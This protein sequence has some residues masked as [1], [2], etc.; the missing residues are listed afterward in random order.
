MKAL[1]EVKTVENEWKPPFTK[2]I[3]TEHYSVAESDEFDR[4]T[5]NGNDEAVFAL[6]GLEGDKAKIRFS[7]LFTPK[8]SVE[9]LGKDKTLLLPR[10][11]EFVVTYL[12]G[13]KG[14]TKK[15]TFQGMSAEEEREEIQQAQP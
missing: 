2:N 11:Q 15:I 12:W 3:Y 6:L 7:R 4:I 5:S 1:F 14:V 13:E 10:G 8:E 9:G